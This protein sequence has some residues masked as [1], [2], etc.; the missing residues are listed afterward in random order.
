MKEVE[1][2]F[3]FSKDGKVRDFNGGTLGGILSDGTY[4][5]TP[6]LITMKLPSGVQRTIKLSIIESEI[7]L[8]SDE[9]FKY[10]KVNKNAR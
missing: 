6:E 7:I 9:G 1:D 4:H 2:W 8:T 10:R 5:F 3:E